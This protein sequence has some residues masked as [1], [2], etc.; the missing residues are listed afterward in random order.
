MAASPWWTAMM[1]HMMQ[2]EGVHTAWF[3][4]CQLGMETVDAD[5]QK[6]AAKKEDNRHDE[7]REPG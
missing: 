7:L 1:K 2:L 6:Q 3:G 5:G 4:L